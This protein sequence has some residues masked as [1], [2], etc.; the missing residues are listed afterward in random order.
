VRPLTI[1][2]CGATGR[3]G[4]LVPTLLERGHR[5]RAATRQPDSPA[6]RALARMGAQPVRADLDDTPG[7]VSAAEGAD[8]V[9][10]AGTAHAAGPQGDIRHG[11]N[12][13]DAA[14][15]AGVRHLVYIS[16]AAADR[17]TGVPPFDSKHVVEHHIR[18][19]G[20]PY[21]VIAPVYYMDN[22]WN[23]WNRPALSAGR[24]PSPVPV[25]RRIQQVSIADVIDFA[26]V[27]MESP[28][29]FV[30]ERVVV[31]AD[32]PNAQECAATISGIVGRP[33]AAV[34]PFPDGP[35][36]LF[37]WLNREGDRVDTSAVRT[38]YPHIQWH[39]F[40]AWAATQD[41]SVLA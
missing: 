3:L 5:V 4:Q 30:G 19:V 32:Q 1:L 14:H 13:A 28:D 40:A 6:A 34:G 9:F 41:W 26:A 33:V 38:A 31:A 37:D 15:I 2:V 18:E 11:V 16:V 25:T 29:R 7:L 22:V 20:V 10:A 12:V 39:D 17:P 24:F 8:V 35:N 21:T 27:V 36:P 23:P